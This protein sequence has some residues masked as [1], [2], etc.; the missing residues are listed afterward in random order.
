MTSAREPLRFTARLRV[1]LG[2]LGGGSFILGIVGVFAGS[3]GAGTAVLV[4]FGG[5]LL[6]LAL[7]GDRIEVLEIGGTGLRLRRA[8]EELFRR[9]DESEHAG[10]VATAERLRAEG[11]ALLEAA[12]VLAD[13]YR[14]TR[15]AMPS[16][17][18]RTRIL[19]GMVA[20]ARRL[21]EQDSLNV[22]GADVIR[23]LREGD[24]GQRVMALSMMQVK[25][26]W[27][28]F[29]A[30]LRRIEQATSAFEQYHAMLVMLQMAAELDA[31][32]RRRLDRAVRNVRGRDFP[33]DSDRWHLSE[34]I[35]RRIGTE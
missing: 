13:A 35:L 26:D 33:Q 32:Q 15:S 18:E 25:R 19:E 31:G 12:G 6:V 21:A 29:D 10:D 28:D 9:A 2:I 34:R 24:E 16:G 11:R 8:A 3:D 1:T 17:P 23:W 30:V 4:A 22:N 27:R 7:L 20:G 5:I 14:S